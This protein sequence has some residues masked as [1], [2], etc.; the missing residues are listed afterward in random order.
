MQ[1]KKIINHTKHVSVRWGDDIV[2]VELQEIR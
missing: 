1:M 2:E